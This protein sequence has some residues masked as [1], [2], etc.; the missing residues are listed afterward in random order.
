MFALNV[1]LTVRQEADIERVAQ[2]LTECVRFSR[3][4]EGCLMYEACHSQTDPR[5]FMLCERW[6]SEEAWK[7]HREQRAYKE[8]CATGDSAG[9]P[10]AAPVHAA[11]TFVAVFAAM[12]GLWGHARA[13]RSP[14]APR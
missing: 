6:A 2:L 14:L 4:E 11:R 8:F 13:T 1:V 7:A 10:R 5:I 3:E 9:R 12:N